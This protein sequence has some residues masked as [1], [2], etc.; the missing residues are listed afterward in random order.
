M[1]ISFKKIA[2]LSMVLNDIVYLY[3]LNLDKHLLFMGVQRM[4]NEDRKHQYTL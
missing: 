4:S 3:G 2:V 1:E